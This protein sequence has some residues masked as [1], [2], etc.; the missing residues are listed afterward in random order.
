MRAEGRIGYADDII[1]RL[2]ALVAD[3]RAVRLTTL[4]YFIEMALMEARIQ[5]RAGA[6]D[7]LPPLIEGQARIEDR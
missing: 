4:A 7:K 5:E 2:E 1:G 3:C 6:F